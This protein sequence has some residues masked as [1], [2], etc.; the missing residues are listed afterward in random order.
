MQQLM[1]TKRYL[2]Y[3]Y[4]ISNLIV[5]SFLGS[6]FQAN[7]LVVGEMPNK[8]ENVFTFT[9]FPSGKNSSM[10]QPAISAVSFTVPATHRLCIE[11]YLMNCFTNCIFI[12]SISFT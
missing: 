10:Q 2:Y 8:G 1:L 6:F 7:V 12:F 4:S 5:N 3:R 9:V 11:Q